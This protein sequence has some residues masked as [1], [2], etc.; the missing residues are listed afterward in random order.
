MILKE[1]SID[2]YL[3]STCLFIIDEFNER[4]KFVKTKEELKEIAD[5]EFNES[6]LTV[7]LGYNPI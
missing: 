7:N 5:L 3:I 2:Q 1:S 6:D 4:F